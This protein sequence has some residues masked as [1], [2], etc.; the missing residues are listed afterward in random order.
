MSIIAKKAIL[1]LRISLCSLN[2]GQRSFTSSSINHSAKAVKFLKAQRR[3]Q[4]NEAKQATL[5]ASTDKVDPVLG[6]T[7]TPFITRIM[8]ELKE[9]LVL[10]K[11]YNIEEVDKFLVAIE[12]AKR[13]RAE[14]SGLNTEVVGLEDIQSIEARREAIL[15]ILSMRNSENKNAI[16]LAVDLAR[17]EFERFPG[18]TGSSEVQAACMTVRIQNM[19]NHIKEHRKDF[20]NTRNLRILV[21]QRQAILRYLKRDNPEKYYWTIQKLGLNDAAITDE[22]NMDRRYMQ[23][24][25][26]FGD[27]VL[28][29]DSKKVADQKRKEIRRQKRTTF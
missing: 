14:L 19:A 11:G 15:R 21:Q 7:D 4:K 2:I 16:K 13:E 1:N 29:K 10:S 5:K 25:E 26:F 3:K 8:A 27:K 24:Y 22:F 6:R 9:P 17:K 18:D 12:A 20:A 28:I 23:D